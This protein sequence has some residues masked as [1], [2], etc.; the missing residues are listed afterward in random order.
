M[1]AT[2]PFSFRG[3]ESSAAVTYGAN[4]D[5]E[6]WGYGLLGLPWPSTLA[7]GLPVLQVEVSTPVEGYAAV[8]GWIQ[9]RAHPRGGV[10]HLARSRKR[11]RATGRSHLGRRAASAAGARRAVRVVRALPDPLSTPRHRPRATFASSPTPSS[12]PCPDALISKRSQPCF[13]LR[14][15]YATKLGEHAELILADPA[16]PR[17][18]GTGHTL[19]SRNSFPTGVRAHRLEQPPI[20]RQNA[21]GEQE[22][23]PTISGPGTVLSY[24]R[25]RRASRSITATRGA[26]LHAVHSHPRAQFTGRYVYAQM[27]QY[28]A[29]PTRR[30]RSSRRAAAPATPQYALTDSKT[31]QPVPNGAPQRLGH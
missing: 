24:V 11:E 14:W 20:A 28:E 22:P 4:D 17:R 12:R 2:H 31:G 3:H 7:T 21:E 13:G 23:E 26:L 19:C 9:A 15:G 16:R 18:L 10:E 29:K 6:R 30:S 1:E 27:G 25:R 8:M 5:P